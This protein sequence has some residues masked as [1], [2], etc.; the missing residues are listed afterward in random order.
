MIETIETQK[1]EAR[2][3]RQVMKLRG[4]GLVPAILYGHG[5]ENICLAIREEAVATLIR[6][7]SKL[8]NLTGE[9]KDTALL[10]DV[11]WDSLGSDIIHLDFARVS[12]AELV[13]VTLPVE[14]HG[15]APGLA[16]GGQ[17]RFQTHLMSIRCPAGLIPEH[18]VVEVGGLHLGQSIHA[19]EVKLPEGATTVTPASIVIVQIVSPTATSDDVATA[20]ATEPELIRKEKPAADA[21]A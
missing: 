20:S 7:G 13:E 19:G 8:V 1:R 16:E 14:L 4:Q 3:T 10:R 9:V 11:Q 17:L 21:K 5:E 12:Q 2:G 6:H 18:I 15:E